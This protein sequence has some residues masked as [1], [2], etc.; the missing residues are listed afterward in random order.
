MFAFMLFGMLWVF[1]FIG[2]KT[3]YITMVSAATYYFDSN[4]EKNGSASVSTAFS[5]AYTKNIGS[6]ALGSLILTI[7]GILRSIVENMA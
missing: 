7:V 1:Q 6:L 5:F 4:S 2:D 3:K